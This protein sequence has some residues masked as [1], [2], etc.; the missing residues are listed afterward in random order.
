MRYQ[1]HRRKNPLLQGERPP[2]RTQR[3]QARLTNV[4]NKVVGTVGLPSNNT[5]GLRHHETVLQETRGKATEHTG[6]GAA[7][8]RECSH[9]VLHTAAHHSDVCF[10]PPKASG[11]RHNLRKAMDSRGFLN[12]TRRKT[13]RHVPREL[14]VQEVLQPIPQAYS[15]SWETDRTG[16]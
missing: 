1:Q 5:Q 16:G 11:G 9:T 6:P 2:P 4:A 15:S 7:L 8:R 12:D 14:P 10:S 13:R 3:M